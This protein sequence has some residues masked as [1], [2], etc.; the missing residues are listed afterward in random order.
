MKT[1]EP[2]WLNA[3]ESA[4][5][6]ALFRMAT[7]L[8]AALDADLQ[9][10]AELSFFE[11]QVLAGLSMQPERRMRM[12]ILAEFSA[13]SLS[14]LSHTARRLESKGWLQRTP[15]PT[16]G[17][18][19]LAILTDAGW[20]KVVATAPGHVAEVRRVLFDALT[21][22]QFKQLRQISDRVND[23]IGNDDCVGGHNAP[24]C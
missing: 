24:N 19:T 7:R 21:Q 6:L 18:Y 5:W 17:R 10:H 12:S 20:E 16:D 13:S 23:A 2:R 11:Y 3:D 1:E 8:P 22:A 15:D 14:R 9:R 4:T